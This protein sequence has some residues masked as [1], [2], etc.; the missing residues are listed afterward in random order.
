MKVLFL[1]KGLAVHRSVCGEGV[2]LD[3]ESSHEFEVFDVVFSEKR[4]FN[5]CV[6]DF[7]QQ[8]GV[9]GVCIAIGVFDGVHLGHQQVVKRMLQDA[10]NYDSARVV[11]TF[12]RHPKTVIPHAKPPLMITTLAHK[13]KLMESLGVDYT[14]LIP[15]DVELSRLSGECFVK[16]LNREV[17]S[18]RS[19]SVGQNFLFG[20][21]RQG[22]VELL[23]EIGG[24]MGFSV[25]GINPVSLGGRTIS[26][27]R[28]R[29][30]IGGGDLEI[31]SQMLG[32]EYSIFSRVVRG[33][34]IGRRLGFPTANL[35][36]RGL[37]LPPCGVYAARV[38]LRDKEYYGVLNL[39]YRP[40][41]S[42]R[43]SVLS[44]EVHLFDFSADIYSENIEVVF[45]EKLRDEKRFASVDDLRSQIKADIEGA[46]RIFRG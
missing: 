4:V 8:N 21:N 37:V 40:T 18:I 27:T 20:H 17:G 35:D 42:A 41:V 16:C 15:F 32:R 38:I 6:R 36:I 46:L 7:F 28:I 3:S 33:E 30:A 5:G 25:N 12:D 2:Y 44:C 45:V 13:L 19:V 39:G 22:S 23:K 1:S 14:V 24:R 10:R 9:R 29:E 43:S 11:V 26:S 31:A 34:G